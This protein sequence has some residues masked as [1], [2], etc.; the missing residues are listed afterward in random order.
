[1]TTQHTVDN[2]R[3]IAAAPTQPVCWTLAGARWQ[4]WK[5]WRSMAKT[6]PLF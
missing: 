1:M 5:A 6:H 2:A 3:L 4:T